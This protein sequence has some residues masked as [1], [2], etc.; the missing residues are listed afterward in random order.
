MFSFAIRRK[1][2]LD[3]GVSHFRDSMRKYRCYEGEVR[4]RAWL[5]RGYEDI[6][7]YVLESR[8]PDSCQQVGDPLMLLRRLRDTLEGDIT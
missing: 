1:T 5:I 2:D 7:M 3:F 4:W 8:G 6:E